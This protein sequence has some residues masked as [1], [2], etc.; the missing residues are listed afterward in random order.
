MYISFC[1]HTFVNKIQYNTTNIEWYKHVSF[2]MLPLVH[3]VNSSHCIFR[4]QFGELYIFQF[5]KSIKS[6]FVK[7]AFSFHKLIQ[8][9]AL[10][11]TL[12]TKLSLYITAINRD[13]GWTSRC[14]RHKTNIIRFWNRL[15]SINNNHLPKIIFNWDYSCT[16]GPPTLRVFLM[17][18][19]AKT[20]LFQNHRF[21][22]TVVEHSYM[23]YNV[24]NG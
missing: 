5:L 4:L 17:T 3:W 13:M 14:V 18:L 11:T 16:H 9:I 2:L 19:I 22:W 12:C 20:N 10:L 7:A 24:N 1:Y 15:M 21:L 6:C 8:K 23:N